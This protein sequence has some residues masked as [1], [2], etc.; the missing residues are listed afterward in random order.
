MKFV[1]I[2]VSGRH[3]FKMIILWY[4]TYECDLIKLIIGVFCMI[5]LDAGGLTAI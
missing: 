3:L 5:C 2:I 1:G 4:N